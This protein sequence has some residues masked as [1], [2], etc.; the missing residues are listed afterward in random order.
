MKKNKM[1]ARLCFVCFGLFTY[2]LRDKKEFDPMGREHIKMK[3]KRRE[4]VWIRMEQQV[5]KCTL[6]R[7][8]YPHFHPLLRRRDEEKKGREKLQ[9]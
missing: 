1:K 2:F 7:K 9:R 5:E 3:R 6:E 4:R 8:G